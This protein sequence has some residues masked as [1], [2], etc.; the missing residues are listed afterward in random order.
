MAAAR[1]VESL[2][3]KQGARRLLQTVDIDASAPDKGEGAFEAWAPN[4]ITCLGLKMPEIKITPQY[5]ITTGSP[6]DPVSKEP[7]NP[8][9]FQWGVILG[10]TILTPEGFDPQMHRYSIKLPCGTTY[11]TGDH[12]AILPQNEDGAVSA[13]LAALKLHRSS[14]R[15]RPSCPRE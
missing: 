14:S 8:L 15:S 10:S 6:D 2:L 5:T 1:K 7:M 11:K 12:V 4:A 9:G 3:Q 13:V